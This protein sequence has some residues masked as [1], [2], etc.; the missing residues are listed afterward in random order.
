MLS[1]VDPRT[2]TINLGV[3]AETVLHGFELFHTVDALWVCLGVHETRERLSELLTA[4]SISHPAE[5]R[6]VPVDFPCL[7]I[8]ST[9]GRLSLCF[10]A[11]YC[12]F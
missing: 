10:L 6:T 9:T 12:R 1:K 2:I 7:G 8:E 11:F 4:G 3:L 5:T